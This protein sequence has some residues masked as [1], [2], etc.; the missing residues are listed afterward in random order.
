V[1]TPTPAPAPATS[2]LLDGRIALVTGAT[3]GIGH[4]I[5][6]GLGREGAQVVAVGRTQ[7]ALE[8]LDDEIRAAGG[9]A[10]SLVE[11]DLRDGDGIDRLG[12]AIFER[13]G[14]LDVLVGAAGFL[15]L[16]TPVG[17]LDQKVWDQ[18]IAVNLTANYRLLRSMDPLLRRAEAGRVLLLSSGVARDPRAFWGAYAVSKAGLEALASVYA[19]EVDNTPIRVA[20][21]NPGPMRTR[22]RAKAYPGEDPDTLP[23]PEEIVPMVIEMV[24]PG[25]NPSPAVVDFKGWK[26]TATH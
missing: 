16:M 6:V 13:H 23:A 24:G 19:D 21:I 14:R 26:K 10:A 17:H 12:A 8:S 18:V 1:N 5:A 3:H 20:V 11:L 25:S 7:G 2:S 9:S 15:G 4:A 22:M